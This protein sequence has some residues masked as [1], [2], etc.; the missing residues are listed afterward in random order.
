MRTM[1]IVVQPGDVYEL[2]AV[3]DYIRIKL[4]AVD[5]NIEN[6]QSGDN[7]E[8]SQGDDFEMT[9]FSQLNISHASGSAQTIKILVSKGKKANSSPVAG[10]VTV[11]NPVALD[12]A[13]L[14]ALETIQ[15]NA[16]IVGTPN[17]NITGLVP[18]N[19]GGSNAQKTVTNVSTLF[20]AAN[21][22]R[23]YLLI[24]NNDPTGDIYIVFG[25]AATLTTGIKIAANGGVLELNCNI[26]TAAI[27][28]IGS[29]ATQS[30]VVVVEG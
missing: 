29:L 30:N 7:F 16:T 12:S 8:A 18:T 27:Y 11:S 5:I 14:A 10:S 21:A 6:V 3:G 28:A 4:A 25:G 23:K 15:T 26:L 9:P 1:T 19:A 22:N 13:T 17:V 20:L 2:G 24:Q